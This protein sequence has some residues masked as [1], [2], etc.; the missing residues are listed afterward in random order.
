MKAEKVSEMQHSTNVL[1]IGAAKA[2]ALIGLFLST[3]GGQ[4][5]VLS[6]NGALVKVSPDDASVALEQ[7][8]DIQVMVEN[9]ANLYGIDVRVLFDPAI[10]EVVDVN[11]TTS[12]VQVAPGTFP[13][14]DFTVKNETD[15]AL[16]LVWYVVTQLNPRQPASGSGAI[17]TI[18]FRA[19]ATG[20]SLV[21]VAQVMMVDRDGVQLPASVSGGRVNVLGAGGE[22][23][24]PPPTRTATPI[25]SPTPTPTAV[26]LG[27]TAAATP[28]AAPTA[29]WTL[30][31]PT[32]TN[33]AIA[34]A[35][36]TPRATFTAESTPGTNTTPAPGATALPTRQNPSPSPSPSA[37][38]AGPTPAHPPV[39]ALT[40]APG[41][42]ASASPVVQ[43][44]PSAL[45]TTRLRPS[46]TAPAAPTAP[47]V[48]PPATAPGQV[49]ASLPTAPP[50]F[51]TRAARQIVEP[52]IPEEMFICM[53]VALVLFAGLLALYLVRRERHTE[54]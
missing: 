26:Q 48:P 44:V 21:D 50:A 31:V 36:L 35:S 49:A 11:A 28:S 43:A 24:V 54:P 38:P 14:P 23:P 30:A 51:P 10:L 34:T 42:T 19:K 45:V 41:S 2:L 5:K 6:Q 37:T 15:N 33:G 25:L 13:Y 32:S 17:M 27:P 40:S 20:S 16:G 47:A 52:V 18:R 22:T 7:T 9:I 3:L 12:G 1:R 53:A 46:A 39:I 29:S 8:I 4:P